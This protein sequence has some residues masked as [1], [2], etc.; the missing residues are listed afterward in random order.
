MSC[1]RIVSVP[2]PVGV[3]GFQGPPGPTGPPGVITGLNTVINVL[4]ADI[5]YGAI[6]SQQVVNSITYTFPSTGGP[7]R[8]LSSFTMMYLSSSSVLFPP[9][10][11]DVVAWI[12]DGTESFAF[13]S[14]HTPT[15]QEGGI[16]GQG[17][18]QTIYANG[19]VVTFTSRFCTPQ[20]TGTVIRAASVVPGSTNTTN[21]EVSCVKSS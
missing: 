16:T 21:L 14:D 4:A 11:S 17:V 3:A 1:T 15:S 12:T 6:N 18:T 13:A 9:G 19:Q 7:W 2:G 20:N 5:P 8:A 10:G